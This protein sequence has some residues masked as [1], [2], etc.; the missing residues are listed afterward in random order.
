MF[1]WKWTAIKLNGRHSRWENVVGRLGIDC[2][3]TVKSIVK[4]QLTFMAAAVFHCR[5]I[6]HLILLALIHLVPKMVIGFDLDGLRPR[7]GAA[8]VRYSV[9]IL[10]GLDAMP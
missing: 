6:Q 8:A 10:R 1:V 5:F 9:A 2:L 7:C 3:A 4:S